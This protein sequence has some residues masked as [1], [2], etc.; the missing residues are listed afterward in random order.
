[1]E[2]WHPENERI[3]PW[4]QAL[5]AAGVDVLV[6]DP[7]RAYLPTAGM[8]RLITYAVPTTTELEDRDVRETSVWKVV[9][10]VASLRR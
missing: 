9:A 5:A 10:Q 7:G 4:F 1:M 8:L 6:A 3:W 2:P